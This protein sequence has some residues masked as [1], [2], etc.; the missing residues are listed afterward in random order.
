MLLLDAK[1]RYIYA[2]TPR[3]SFFPKNKDFTATGQ[4]EV[5]RLIEKIDPLIVGVPQEKGDTRRQIFNKLVHNITMDNY[6]SGDY[7]MNI[8]VR[9]VTRQR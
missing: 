1:R 6:F 8:L 3:H 9:E 5:I 7:V 4:A 2:W